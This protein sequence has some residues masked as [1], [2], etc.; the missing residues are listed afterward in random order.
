MQQK[1]P[2]MQRERIPDND[3]RATLPRWV[4]DS[5]ERCVGG[6]DVHVREH[7]RLPQVVNAV[8]RDPPHLKVAQFG[9]HDVRVLGVL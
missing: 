5:L 1:G 6:V 8:G 4:E 2:E 3:E 9:D 7:G